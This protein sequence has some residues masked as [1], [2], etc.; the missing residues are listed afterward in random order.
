M[1]L[2]C[3]ELRLRCT[4]QRSIERSRSVVDLLA[5]LSSCAAYHGRRAQREVGALLGG[6]EVKCPR[7]RLVPHLH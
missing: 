2:G 3:S 7:P 5:S 6:G 1:R 4:P